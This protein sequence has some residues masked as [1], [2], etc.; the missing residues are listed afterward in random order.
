MGWRPERVGYFAF[1]LG[2]DDQRLARLR[3]SKVGGRPGAVERERPV[4]G[5]VSSPALDEPQISR[6]GDAARV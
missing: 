2:V 6:D 3:W 1:G 5:L 4:Y